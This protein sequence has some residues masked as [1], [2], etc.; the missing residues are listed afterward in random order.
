MKAAERLD[1]VKNEKD[2]AE[3]ALHNADDTYAEGCELTNHIIACR[4]HWF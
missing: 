1:A 2:D 4:M 3:F